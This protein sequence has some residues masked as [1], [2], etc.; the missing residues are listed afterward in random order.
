MGVAALP[1][2]HALPRCTGRGW[3]GNM[4]VLVLVPAA[5]CDAAMQVIARR[6]EASVLID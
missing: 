6:G 5:F 4:I 3:T 2:S 1:A